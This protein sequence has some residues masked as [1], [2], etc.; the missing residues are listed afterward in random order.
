MAFS[1]NQTLAA[2][3]LNNLS[4]LTATETHTGVESFSGAGNPRVNVAT[5]LVEQSATPATPGAGNAR[6]FV[7][8]ANPPLVKVI[9]DDGDVHI[10]GGFQ[11]DETRRMWI[12]YDRDL[13]TLIQASDQI[14]ID[15]HFFP[16]QATTATALQTA[17][18]VLQGSATGATTFPSALRR[19]GGV[20]ISTAGAG[21][22]R[23]A[24]FTGS[25]V[26][27]AGTF[28]RA[29]QVQFMAILDVVETTSKVIQ[30]G[31]ALTP[32]DTLN[33]G[34]D[35][36]YWEYDSAAQADWVGVVRTGAANTDAA[37]TVAAGAGQIHLLFVVDGGVNVRFYTRTASSQV[38]TLRGTNAGAQPAAGTDLIPFFKVE[39]LA[40]AAKS[41][42]MFRLKIVGNLES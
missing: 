37:S 19:G 38:W 30:L 41:L 17:H 12:A 11:Y 9:Q 31:L 7:D 35:G 25:T 2:A 8:N 29:D 18:G 13:T 36:I 14:I 34:A 10:V 4:D 40:A 42:D 32:T 23:Q 28:R 33:P 22:D 26:T 21:N 27:N 24:Y 5:D 16:G 1:T 39:T 6:L 20:R 15:E 3:D